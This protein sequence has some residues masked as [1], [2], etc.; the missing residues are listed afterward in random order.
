MAADRK[1]T[2]AFDFR[3]NDMVSYKGAAVKIM[4]LLHP[5]KLGYAKAKIRK[6]T[7]DDVVD[8]SVNYSDLAPLGTARPELMFERSKSF[9]SNTPIFYETSGGEIG[10]GIIVSKIG[11]NLTVHESR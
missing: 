7:H 3:I 4:E 2:T 8:D 10:A 6:V 5:L 9:E 1:R 11:I